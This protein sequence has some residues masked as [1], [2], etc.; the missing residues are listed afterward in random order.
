[1]YYQITT[2]C[3]MSCEHCSFACEAKGEDMTPETMEL[4][5]VIVP[6]DETPMIGGGEP[7]L[8][9]LFWNFLFNVLSYCN[10]SPPWLATNGKRTKDAL[11][12]CRLA[13]RGV[14]GCALSLDKWHDPIDPT[15]VAA[16]K[17]GLGHADHSLHTT[18]FLDGRE[19]RDV[20]EDHSV[21]AP[22]RR[23]LDGGNEEVCP[24]QSRFVTPGGDIKFCGCRN[25]PV[26]GHVRDGHVP[27][28]DEEA[29]GY[30]CWNEYLRETEDL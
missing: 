6:C 2:R 28:V 26:I 9:P 15:V 23:P 14:I 25:A 19:I 21:L 8:H 22:F 3:N 27:D 5:L 24:V 1:M 29:S 12:L 16:F 13:K 11:R 10:E 18:D 4:C 30:D 20:G 17:K 7:T